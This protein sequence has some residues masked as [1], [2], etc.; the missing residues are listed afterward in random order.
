MGK[1]GKPPSRDRYEKNF[2]N[3]TVRMPKEWHVVTEVFLKES[4]LS[5]REF[6]AIALEKQK[7]NFESV[8][9]QGWGDGY[10]IGYGQGERVG[11]ALGQKAGYE[12]GY[13]VGLNEG[14]K[15]GYER[16][17]REGIL[18]GR[19]QGDN[20]GYARGQDEW[21]IWSFCPSCGEVLFIPPNSEIHE[22]IIRFL[23]DHGWGH[24]PEC[25][26]RNFY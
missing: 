2:P 9:W 3:W 26:R 12:N 21:R 25:P 5:R 10:G 7:M 15:Q 20:E 13:E 18:Q 4:N 16:G 11:G 1:K 24:Y 6:M 14:D 8:R 17:R 19:Y 23:M 22:D